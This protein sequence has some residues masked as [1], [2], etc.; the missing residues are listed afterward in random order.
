MRRRTG[1]IA[2]LLVGSLVAA[3]CGGDD[4]DGQA[5]GA[6]EQTD[7]ASEELTGEPIKI[8]VVGPNESNV[9]MPWVEESANVAAAAVNADG[10]I[11]GRPIEIVFCDHKSTPEGASVCAQRL[12]QEEQVL[13]L[14]GGEGSQDGALLPAV[15][16]ADTILWS[17]AGAS[18]DS[19]SNER[20]YLLLPI[21]VANWGVPQLLPDDLESFAYVSAD[22]AVAR[23]GR[24]RTMA[25]FPE[26]VAIEQIDVPYTATDFQP[27]CLTVRQ[28]EA[29]AVMTAFNPQ[30]IPTMMQTCNQLGLRDLT[31]VV[32]SSVITP[33][34]LDLMD[35]L[36]LDNRSVQ[37]F[38][39]SAYEGLAADNEEFGPEVGEVSNLVADQSVATWLG[40][41]L[42]PQLVEGAGA[43]DAAAIRAWLDQQTEFDTGGAT[44]PAGLHGQTMPT[45]PRIKNVTPWGGEWA[46]GTAQPDDEPLEIDFSVLAG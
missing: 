42:L 18:A 12:L 4:D 21:L 30:Q 9:S 1:W 33:E 36:G 38:N 25:F 46:D 44:P 14:V 8:G 19:L 24:E 34:I 41:K 45:L 6:E 29:Q 39:S 37:S 10:G 13:M 35:E 32:P 16:A 5:T 31:W 17:T 11:D 28:A 27:Y 2:A 43:V 3:S 7:G 22:A 40:V 26:D 15:E 23:E 20:A